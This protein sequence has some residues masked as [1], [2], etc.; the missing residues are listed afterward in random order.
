MRKRSRAE[1]KPILEAVERRT[2]L[3]ASAAAPAA[4]HPPQVISTEIGV[5]SPLGPFFISATTPKDL[6]I[7]VMSERDGSHSFRP[8]ADIS[9]HGVVIN[10][11][12]YHNFKIRRAPVDENGDG[13]RDAIIT[14][15][16][17]SAI[18]LTPGT[19]ILTVS[20]MTRPGTA[21]AHEEWTGTASV[22]VGGTAEQP[23]TAYV[24]L[25]YRAPQGNKLQINL[26]ATPGKP[27]K[28]YTLKAGI[29]ANFYTATEAGLHSFYFS[30]K[31]STSQFTIGAGGEFPYGTSSPGPIYQ[32]RL[33]SGYEQPIQA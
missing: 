8:L 31:F 10:G 14:V 22:T 27:G 21:V 28:E 2:L 7:Y 5:G 20:G 30:I 25:F 4:A 11:V 1:F 32:H 29:P 17:R 9:R 15:A 19:T 13:I 12:T 16:P 26:K 18:G 3:S 23:F 24:T 6:N 33:H